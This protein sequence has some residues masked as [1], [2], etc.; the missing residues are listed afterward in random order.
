MTSAA[1]TWIRL[2]SLCLPER[3]TAAMAGARG[4]K[5]DVNSSLSS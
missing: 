2:C 4:E 5:G 1:K 3:C